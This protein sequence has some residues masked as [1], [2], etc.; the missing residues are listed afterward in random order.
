MKLIRVPEDIIVA[1]SST[2]FSNSN[3]ERIISMDVPV[4]IAVM[5]LDIISQDLERTEQ[6]ISEIYK[7][8]AKTVAIDPE[9]KI[10][11]IGEDPSNEK[12][13]LIIY[14]DKK[15]TKYTDSFFKRWQDTG[16]L[17]LECQVSNTEEKDVFCIKGIWSDEKWDHLEVYPT[18]T[19]HVV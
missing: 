11:F 7:E 8:M 15:Q 2:K 4:C 17:L 19:I 12:T 10:V 16:M 1:L 6:K 3:D 18:S 5:K 14:Q 13:G 9:K